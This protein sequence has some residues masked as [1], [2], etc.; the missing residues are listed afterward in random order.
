MALEPMELAK[1]VGKLSRYPAI[2][3]IKYDGVPLAFTNIGGHIVPLTRQNEV[4]KSVPHICKFLQPILPKHGDVIIGECL[5]PGQP[6]KVSSGAVRKQSPNDRIVCLV[7]DG[8]ITDREAGYADRMDAVAAA[9]RDLPGD[10]PASVF[11]VA[12]LGIAKSADDFETKYEQIKDKL[13]E[14]PEGLMGHDINKP[15]NPGKRCWGMT[16]YKPQPTLDLLVDSFDE[17]FSEAG[18]PLGMVGRVNVH[19][20]EQGGA[21]SVIGVGPGRMTHD[22]RRRVWRAYLDQRGAVPAEYRMVEV[23]YMPDP[24]YEALRQPTV[25]RFRTDKTEGDIYVR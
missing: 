20:V 17:A 18:E 10:V 14:P 16:R 9:I 7:W 19:L 6:F 21:S 12:N 13:K 23:K 24:T 3:Q 4:A 2:M 8:C 5:I 1:N 11:M 25:Q 22:E 15:F